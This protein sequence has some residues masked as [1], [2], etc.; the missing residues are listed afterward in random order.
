MIVIKKICT[1]IEEIQKENQHITPTLN[2]IYLVLSSNFHNI[3]R[4]NQKQYKCVREVIIRFNK[5]LLEKKM[6]L[7]VTV[8]NIL[9]AIVDECKLS[10]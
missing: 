2:D 4:S 9:Q 10:S 3:V 5:L 1:Q 8:V 7:E 6:S